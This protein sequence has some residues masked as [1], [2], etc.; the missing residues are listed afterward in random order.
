LLL[1]EPL[2]ALDAGHKREILPYLEALPRRFGIPAIYVSHAA[3]EMAR[4][5]D[6][7]IVL[8][9]GRPTAI[10]SA[11]D[12]LGR[13]LPQANVMPFEPVSIFDARVIGQVADLH[14]TR[15]EYHGQ[16]IVVPELRSADVGDTVRLAIRAGDVVLATSEP[17]DLSVRNVLRGT[18]HGISAQAGGAFATVD[19]DVSGTLLSAQVTRQAIAALRLSVGMPVFALIKTAIFDRGL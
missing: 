19:V 12:V 15:V 5:A 1:D 4:L 8:E 2:A 3:S 13:H 10:G 14:L 11:S 18:V 7:V 6:T 16:Q 17:R 9:D